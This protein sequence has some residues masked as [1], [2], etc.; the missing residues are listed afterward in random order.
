MRVTP[1]LWLNPPEV[2]W[3][4]CRVESKIE[5]NGYMVQINLDGE[6]RSIGVPEKAVRVVGDTL[7]VDG[8]LLVVVVAELPDDN[9]LLTELPA[10][11]LSG[12]RR[13][14]VDPKR[15]QVA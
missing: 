2:K 6:Q 13:I 8:N 11:P 14:K 12:S 10:T 3:I 15:L 9:R 5:P 7:P 4:P 1:P